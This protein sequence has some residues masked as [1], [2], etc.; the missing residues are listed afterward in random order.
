MSQ[1]PIDCSVHG[2]AVN[3]VKGGSTEAGESVP[4]IGSPKPGHSVTDDG[5]IEAVDLLPGGSTEVCH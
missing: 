3:H 4:A 2:R 1:C 5:P